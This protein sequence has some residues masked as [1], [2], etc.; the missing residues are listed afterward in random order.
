MVS[1]F[2][3]RRLGRSECRKHQAKI[4]TGLDYIESHP[5]AKKLRNAKKE[6]GFQTEPFF[7]HNQVTSFGAKIR[8]YALVYRCNTLT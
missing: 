8:L 2:K 6:K 4:T 3:Q 5:I 7:I 1:F